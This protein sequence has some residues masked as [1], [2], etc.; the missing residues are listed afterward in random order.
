MKKVYLK[1]LEEDMYNEYKISQFAKGK[2]PLDF[3]KWKENELNSQNKPIKE[4]IKENIALEQDKTETIKDFY[5]YEE[6]AA[7][8]NRTVSTIKRW[9]KDDEH[10]IVLLD[11]NRLE[12]LRIDTLVVEFQKREE[13]QK[14]FEQY[15]EYALGAF[16]KIEEPYPFEEWRQNI[17]SNTKGPIDLDKYISFDEA[18][19]IIGISAPTLQAY[20]RNGSFR[21]LNEDFYTYLSREDVVSYRKKTSEAIEKRSMEKMK[22][23]DK[24]E[25]ERKIKKLIEDCFIGG[26]IRCD[27]SFIKEDRVTRVLIC[28]GN[29]IIRCREKDEMELPSLLAD[30]EGNPLLFK[31]KEES[32]FAVS[33]LLRTFE[34]YKQYR[35]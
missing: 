26:Y 23:R 28:H 12:K 25:N 34:R 7:L 14:L 5:T 4:N 22:A 1:N 33:T 11:N 20:T 32:S 9:I 30:E 29:I 18:L 21:V 24:A 3:E 15:K 35:Y 6:A 31:N 2:T 19:T 27:S 8:L 10:E 16:K 13:T 17:T